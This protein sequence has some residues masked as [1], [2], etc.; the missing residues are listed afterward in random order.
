MPPAAW[1]FWIFSEK[2]QPPRSTNTI[3]PVSEPAGHGGIE[4][5][6]ET[7]VV[8][9][10][11]AVVPAGNTVTGPSMVDVS[12]PDQGWCTAPRVPVTG[13]SSS[14]SCSVDEGTAVCATLNADE[15]AAGEP[16]MNCLSALLP[17]EATVNTPT[18]AAL[19]TACDRSS[20]NGWP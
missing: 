6:G 12:S 13:A 7:M 2:L 11:R 19:S 17:A 16:V 10:V 3:C 20:S 4:T 1:M 18:F 15:A 9:P 8:Q 5:V 14:M